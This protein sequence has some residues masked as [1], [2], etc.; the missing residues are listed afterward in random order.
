MILA[1]DSKIKQRAEIFYI[2]TEDS[3]SFM[4]GHHGGG[5]G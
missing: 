2:T 4:F 1:Q 5:T 3:R